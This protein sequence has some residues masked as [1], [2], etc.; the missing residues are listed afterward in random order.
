[1]RDRKAFRQDPAPDSWPWERARRAVSNMLRR[2][3][4]RARKTN[5][6]KP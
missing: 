1:M 5:K 2:V 6:D 4:F 3:L